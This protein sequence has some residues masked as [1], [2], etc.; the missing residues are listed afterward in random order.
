MVGSQ[1]NGRT[2]FHHIVT[3]DWWKFNHFHGT[4]KVDRFAATATV[5]RRAA[6]AAGEGGGTAAAAA[7]AAAAFVGV[8]TTMPITISIIDNEEASRGPRFR[9]MR[10]EEG[11]HHHH[12]R[13]MCLI[14]GS[15]HDSLFIFSHCWREGKI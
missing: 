13:T 9:K 7:A 15:R 12:K 11:C 8:P 3:E 5:S 6:D 1:S 10:I 14:E 4:I 2:T